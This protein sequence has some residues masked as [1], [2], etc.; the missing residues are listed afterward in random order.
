VSRTRVG[1]L[2][3]TFDPFHNGHLEVAG[4]VRDSGL[5]DVVIV[6]PANDPWQK[7]CVATADQRLEMVRLGISG[8]RGIEVSDVDIR[9]GGPTYTV[10]TLA[11]ISSTHV[12]D[13]V[14]FIVGTDAAAGLPTWHRAEELRMSR[15]FIVVTRPGTRPPQLDVEAYDL[16]LLEIRPVDVS[17]SAIRERVSKGLALTNLV[18]SAVA[19]YITDKGLYR[20]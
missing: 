13:D 6:V 15:S 11:D 18:P 14:T 12:G 16:N 17:S 8:H 20:E 1:V 4:A 9:R 3:G 19:E 5:V 2:G 7:T 10:D